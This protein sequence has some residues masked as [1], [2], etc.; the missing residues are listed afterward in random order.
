MDV[1]GW[2]SWSFDPVV[3]AVVVA[4]GAFYVTM[5]R[6]V[7]RVTGHPVGIGHWGFYATGLLVLFVALESPLDA[8]GDEFLLSAH[9]F[10]HVLIADIAPPLL[11]LGL[12]APVLPLGVPRELLKRTA[13]GGWIG[14]F[15]A[16]ATNPWVALP[17][18]AAAT[19][20]W[21][22]PAVFDYSSQHEALHYFEHL[23]L[24]YTG[25]ALWWMIISP[26]PS[27]RRRSDIARLGYLGFSRAATAFVCLPLT[28]LNHTLYPL[29]VSAP[30]AYGVSALT[31]Q[32][33]AGAGM[34]LVELLVFGI[35][36][37][38]VFVDM[39]ARDERAQALADLASAPR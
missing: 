24:F 12:R 23:T 17:A 19:W 26:L 28:W 7:R 29:Y 25:F 16:V 6:R 9:V 39:L 4:A 3:W 32:R 8:I 2:G 18:W 14:R 30:R 34:C 38:V 10:Q 27:E 35:A 37:S 21:A 33:M 36:L 13:R 15:W 20:I 11:I 22:I 5:L 31:D 1:P